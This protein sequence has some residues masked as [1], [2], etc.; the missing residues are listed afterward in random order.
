M[1]NMDLSEYSGHEYKYEYMTLGRV[2]YF[3]IPL[4][5]YLKNM[6]VQVHIFSH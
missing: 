6:G 2:H 5:L 1:Q 3:T 4:M